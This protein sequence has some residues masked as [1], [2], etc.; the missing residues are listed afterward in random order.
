[1]SSASGQHVRFNEDIDVAALQAANVTLTASNVRYQTAAAQQEALVQVS[2][3]TAYGHDTA[4]QTS[5]LSDPQASATPT[6]MRKR[7]SPTGFKLG[8][9]RKK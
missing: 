3:V 2:N 1:M 7:R 8:F 6:T 9:K 4:N 5:A